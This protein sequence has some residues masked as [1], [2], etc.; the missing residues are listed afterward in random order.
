[1]VTRKKR[2]LFPLLLGLILSLGC[3]SLAFADSDYSISGRVTDGKAAVSIVVS[4]IGDIVIPDEYNGAPI[5]KINSISVQYPYQVTSLTLP[6]NT[7]GINGWSLYGTA[8]YKRVDKKVLGFETNMNSD[9]TWSVL[10]SERMIDIIPRWMKK[11][12]AKSGGVY[13]AGKTLVRV[14]PGYEGDLVVKDGTVSIQEGALSGCTKLGKVTLPDTL[15]YI[16]YGAFADSSVT[17][18]NFPA[19]M[20]N[21]TISGSQR[22][23]EACTF[24]NCTKLKTF[25][26]E[27]TSVRSVGFLAFYNCSSLENI[28]MTKIDSME[29]LCFAKAFSPKAS[30]DLN[31]AGKNGTGNWGAFLNAG[32]G[33]IKFGSNSFKNIGFEAFAGCRNLSSVTFSDAQKSL[34][35]RCFE[36]CSSL[37]DDILKNSSVIS[38]DYRALAGTGITEITIP[39]SLYGIGAAALAD[40]SKLVTLNWKSSNYFSSETP[41]GYTSVPRGALLFAVLNDC[42]AGTGNPYIIMSPLYGAFDYIKQTNTTTKLKTLNIDADPGKAADTV[43]V[44]FGQMPTLET[45]NFRYPAE[46]IYPRMFQGCVSL[47]HLTLSNP[48]ALRTVGSEAFMACGFEEVLLLK[49]VTYGIGAFRFNNKLRKVIAEEGVTS[50][51][52]MAFNSCASIKE[53]SLPESLTE[54][55]W[56]A[57]K[58]AGDGAFVY[59]PAG[60]SMIRDDA[61]A[62]EPY[63]YSTAAESTTAFNL[64]FG[65]DPTIEIA[66]EFYPYSSNYNG[67]CATSGETVKTVWHK[68]QGVNWTAYRTFL[69][70][71]HYFAVPE[72]NSYDV[73]HTIEPVTCSKSSITA[74]DALNKSDVTV[75][76]DGTKLSADAFDIDYDASNTKTG[77]RT[78]KVTLKGSFDGILFTKTMSVNNF[79]PVT[80]SGPVYGIAD[81]KDLSFEINVTAKEPGVEDVQKALGVDAATAKQIVDYANNNGI[82]PQTLLITDTTLTTGNTDKDQ[83][84]SKFGLLKAYAT[85]LTKSSITVKWSKVTGADGY[86][87]FGNLCGKGNKC[88]LIK[89]LAAGKT[90]FKQKKLKKG[91]YYKYIVVAYKKFGNTEVTIS[92]SPTIHAATKGGKNGVAKAVKVTSVGKNKGKKALK[93]TI[94]KGKTAK[95]KA[96]EVKADKPI[97]RHRKLAYESSNTKVATVTKKGSIKAV[98]KGKCKIYVYAQNGVNKVINVTVK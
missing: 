49:N 97:K 1:M 83:A 40:N 58:G 19:G 98:G 69:E 43:L 3:I 6:A 30:L 31:G 65:G 8:V 44:F 82:D 68:T 37:T 15:E 35:V 16:G 94:K 24:Y 95:I 26:I 33:S 66:Y 61:F 2:F 81:P 70:N 48:D 76:I 72:E 60:V 10:D 62:W 54:I 51:P 50:I 55:G 79:R 9:Y 27:A 73:F 57:F 74:G 12:M 89:K 29:A 93:V 34:G 85:K 84:G 5:T 75:T 86:K 90:S 87:I 14:D 78:V 77:K 21:T 91:K 39:E 47:K 32:M 41:E 88:K 52:E 17:E 28:D 36:N 45:V 23:I 80:V 22:H 53:V 46:T 56:A 64:I 59:I 92:A 18:V 71:T 11:S 42:A 63:Q 20:D 38:I 96:S 4:G 67:L 13:Y 7:E 25:K